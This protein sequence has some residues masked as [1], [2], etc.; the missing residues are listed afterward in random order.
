M[1]AGRYEGGQLRARAGRRAGRY[2]RVRAMSGGEWARVQTQVRAGGRPCPSSHHIRYFL[3]YI[4]Y[5]FLLHMRRENP[6]VPMVLRVF[7]KY[8][9]RY[10]LQPYP[11]LYG[12]G[13]CGFG[14]G[15]GKPDPRVT[16]IKPYI[17]T[18]NQFIV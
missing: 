13:L 14:Y 2:E 1:R 12:Y 17:F 10:P 16:R 8:H 7:V 6:R 4:L 11:W 18:I 15:V 9:T 5:F 3:K